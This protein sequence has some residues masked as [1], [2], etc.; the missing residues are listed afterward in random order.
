MRIA[1]TG[2]SGF[3]GR[4]VVAALLRHR[5]D[6][7]LAVRDRSRLAA[8]AGVE[9]VELDIANPS[10]AAIAKLG[11]ADL[12]IHLAWGSLPN[13]KSGF[14]FETELPR[15][16]RFLKNLI[17]A[18]LGSLLVTG[19]CAEYGMQSGPLAEDLPALPVNAYGFAKDALRRQLMFLRETQP[20]ALTW[21]RLFYMYG[22]GQ[23]ANSLLPQLEAAVMRG[24]AVFN[25]SGGEQLR[26]YLNVGEV[27]RQIVALAMAGRDYGIVNVCAGRPTSIRRLVESWIAERGWNIAL[28]LGHYPYVD[29]ESMAFWGDRRRFDAIAGQP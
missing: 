21:T 20:F 18:G 13:Y 28:N 25:M 19:T 7:V 14:H 12:L 4:H 11:K 17:D 9:I 8:V 5:V 29:Y 10:S 1:V 26:D 3:I 24:D 22:E 23:P 27:A 6:V 16:Y 2:A 15:Q